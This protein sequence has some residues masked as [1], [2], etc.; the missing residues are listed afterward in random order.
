MNLTENAQIAKVVK[1]LNRLCVFSA[2]HWRSNPSAY[3]REKPQALATANEILTQ[4]NAINMR[5][6][7]ISDMVTEGGEY[8]E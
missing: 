1:D 3:E 8:L 7:E 2:E 4:M 5:D 6:Q